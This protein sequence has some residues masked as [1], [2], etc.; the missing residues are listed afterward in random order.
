MIAPAFN[1]LKTFYNEIQEGKHADWVVLSYAT[2]KQK[3]C[4][5]A[6][7]RLILRRKLCEMNF[8]HVY[9]NHQICL[10]LSTLSAWKHEAYLSEL[11]KQLVV[12][13]R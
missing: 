12:P 1:C 13:F 3:T 2:L 6:W 5:R 11:T 8:K 9:Q 4:F 10:I 7:K